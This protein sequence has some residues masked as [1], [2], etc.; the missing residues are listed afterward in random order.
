MDTETE[1]N[2]SSRGDLLA[3]IGDQ[4]KMIADQQRV[5]A[6]QQKDIA[7]HQAVITELRRRVE[8]LERRGSPSWP[9]F[10]DAWQQVDFQAAWLRAV[11]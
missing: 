8:Y 3:V 11:G 6:G 2:G 9:V 7:D 10:R 4:Q 1:L 5:I